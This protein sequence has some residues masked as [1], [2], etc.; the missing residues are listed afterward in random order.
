MVQADVAV[1]GARAVRRPVRVHREGVDRPEVALHPTELLHVDGLEEARLKLTDAA[2]GRGHAHGLLPTAQNHVV[3]RRMLHNRVDRPVRLVGFKDLELRHV[4][5]LGLAVRRRRVEE[6]LLL[7]EG[8][9]VDGL[10]VDR[11]L[12]QTLARVRVE[13]RDHPVLVADKN[14]AVQLPVEVYERDPC[15]LG[16][17]RLDR[18]AANGLELRAPRIVAPHLEDLD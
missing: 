14:A 9:A 2:R 11:L 6:R 16:H 15:R 5:H 1:L 8:D 13:N 7:V 4:D 18:E 10:I 3:L 17:A 12:E